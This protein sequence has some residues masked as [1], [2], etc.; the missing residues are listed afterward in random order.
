MTSDETALI[1][2][3]NRG[4]GLAVVAEFAARGLRVIAT[5]RNLGAA[6]ALRDL[7]VR[8]PD[9]IDILQVDMNASATID[10]LVGALAGRRL[11]VALINAGV[12]GPA[13]RSADAATA[14]EIGD[15]MYVNA[16][17]PIRLAR[18]QIGR[19]HV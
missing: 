7:G 19:A 16:V 6:Q 13:H 3:A 9:R 15:L 18:A 2:G 11:D 4:I 12:S 5:A 17:A 1:V 8:Y 14:A 10:A